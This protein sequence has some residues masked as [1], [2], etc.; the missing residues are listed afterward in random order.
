VDLIWKAKPHAVQFEAANP[1]NA[2]EWSMFEDIRKP[3]GKM[4]IPGAV[5]P[6]GSKLAGAANPHQPRPELSRQP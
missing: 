3:E 1:R 4:L 2:H 6:P 5:H